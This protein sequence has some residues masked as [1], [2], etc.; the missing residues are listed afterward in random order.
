[1]N[2]SRTKTVAKV[3]NTTISLLEGDSC[4]RKYD[5]SPGI[6]KHVRG[7]QKVREEY[8][9]G[10]PLTICAYISRQPIVCCPESNA[11]QTPSWNQVPTASGNQPRISKKSMRNRSFTTNKSLLTISNYRM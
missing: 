3:S 11:V 5:N 1:M 9:Q 4:V 10:I 2:S 7:C 6:C 8:N